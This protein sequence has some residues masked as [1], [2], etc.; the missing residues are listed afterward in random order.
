MNLNAQF[1]T[2]PIA[3]LLFVAAFIVFCGIQ[4]YYYFKYFFPLSQHIPPTNSTQTEG[5][6]VIIAA[7]NEA[8][9]IENCIKQLV[10]QS[11]TNFE[12][13]VVNDY[14]EDRTLSI[15]EGLK[16]SSLVV[17]N[18]ELLSGKKSALSQGIEVAKHKL[19]LFTDADCIPN[20]EKWISNMARHFSV[21]KDIVLGFGAFQKEG[22][23]LNRLIRF[24][25][26]IGALQYFGFANAG[27]AYMG[28]GRNLAYRKSIFQSIGGFAEHQTILS[29]DDDLL[30]NKAATSVNI[31][32]EMEE[33]SHTT[34]EAEHS[35]KRFILQKRRQLS[36]GAHYKK[37][38]K[39]RL[40]IF[41]ASSFLF[42]TLFVTLLV[43]SPFKLVIIGI[44]VMKQFLQYLFF[45]RIAVRLKADDLL[46]FVFIL[47]P[48]YIFSLTV[49]GVSTWFWKVKQ[50]K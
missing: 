42:Y 36:A 12:I 23:L 20:S 14:S 5:V 30:V 18:N 32:I 10:K 46:P 17:L 6:S 35:W 40:A 19:L 16:S 45:K 25:G 22:T 31:S 1:T 47:E 39:V 24:E 21:E 27:K 11:Y 7:K 38:D 26:F 4:V 33:E 15:L 2:A 28:V 8:A 44:F 34:T 29:G 37:K 50:W 43:I 41:G 48:I 13:V 49:I 9:T 3:E